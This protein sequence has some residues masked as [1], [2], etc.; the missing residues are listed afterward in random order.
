MPNNLKKV[1]LVGAGYMA[2]EY[3]KVLDSFEC[4][5]SVVGRS[6][7]TAKEFFEKTKKKVIV[8]G[9]E[10]STLEYLQY[11]TAIVAVSVEYL[12]NVV[13]HLMARGV[14][15]ILVEKPAGLDLA[16]I[17]AICNVAKETKS[18]VFVAYNRRFYASVLEA[19]RLSALD[20]G[21]KS[22]NFEFTE[23]SHVI[24]TLKKPSI[25]LN[26]WFLTNSSHVIDLAFFL[27]GEPEKIDCYVAGTTSWYS[28]ASIFAGAGVSKTG[29]L[30]SYQANW[31]S[32][33]RWSVEILTNKHRYILR[34]MEKLHLQKCGSVEVEAV[35]ID[36]SFDQKF[37]PGLY[38][39]TQAFINNGSSNEDLLDI[40]QHAKNV[41]I[42]EKIE[43]KKSDYS[44]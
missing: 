14:K 6:E 11:D 5:Y 37:K 13:I 9:I 24:E 18:Q 30:F 35:I 44:C 32:A 40:F 8:G 29:A 22:F 36:D 10:A 33:G 38:L 42:F 2:Y 43:G 25:V 21:V 16:E 12:K 23:W 34:P 7:K 28:N 1:L 15:K 17:K 19:K 41:E 27:G 39:Q 26:N 3:S 4:E 31:K 20:G